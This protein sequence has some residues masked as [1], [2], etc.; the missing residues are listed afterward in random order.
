MSFSTRCMADADWATL[1][2]FTP[3]EFTNPEKMGM[4]FIL[5]LDRVRNR[6][7][8]PMR[9]TSSYRTPAHNVAVG[10][11]Q[12]SAHEDTPCNAV[13]IGKS[14][15]P[16]DPHW[17]RARFKIVTAALALGCTRIGIYADG[18][19]H[20]DRTEDVRP[21]NECWIQVDNPAH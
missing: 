14:P 7:G 6:A 11:A 10:G 1:A 21:A 17:N 19:L 9:V 12:N 16:D 15:T 20:L 2:F 4:E 18:S 5:W 3:A 8:V 13:D